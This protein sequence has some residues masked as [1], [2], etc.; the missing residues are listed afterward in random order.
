MIDIGAKI[1][2]TAIYF[3]LMGA[4]KV[5]SVEPSQEIFKH[6]EKNLELNNLSSKVNLFLAGCSN[7]ITS[8]ESNYAEQILENIENSI[9]ISNDIK[10]IPTLSLEDLIKD[11]PDD[12]LILKIDCEGCEYDN[13]LNTPDHILKKFDQIQIEYHFGY[14][15]LKNKLEK[16]G[17]NVSVS[18]PSGTGYFYPLSALKIHVGYLYAEN[19]E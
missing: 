16:C 4:K 15:N 13:I 3:A 12:R 11:Y 19:M 14:S 7:S 9:V 18:K 1:G 8:I 5:I 2:D 10:K 6:A 17:F